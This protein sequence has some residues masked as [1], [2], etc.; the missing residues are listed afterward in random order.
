MFEK[1]KIKYNISFIGRKILLHSL[2]LIWWQKCHDITIT[3]NTPKRFLL[4]WL[5]STSAWF[6]YVMWSL[7]Q[8]DHALS[9]LTHLWKSLIDWTM[10]LNSSRYWTLH[11]VDL[12]SE[13]PNS[14]IK[15]PPVRSIDVLPATIDCTMRPDAS[16]KSSINDV[17]VIDV[18]VEMYIGRGEP[19]CLFGR[20]DSWPRSLPLSSWKA[21]VILMQG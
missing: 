2:T 10:C 16:M 18:S 6:G 15:W 14:D 9:K 13:C 19:G 4:A 8:S 1:I 21:S 3:T 12:Y 7:T 11:A 5:H 17:I 20:F